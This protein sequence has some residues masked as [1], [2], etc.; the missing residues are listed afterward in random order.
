MKQSI[1]KST[2]LRIKVKDEWFLVISMS[3]VLS[4]CHVV[5]FKG[6]LSSTIYCT[7]P[8]GCLA[9]RDG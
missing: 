1:I 9:A 3:F 7:K 6:M 8:M 5:G 2:D 4:P